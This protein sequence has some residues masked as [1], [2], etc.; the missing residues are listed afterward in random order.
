MICYPG[1]RVLVLSRNFCVQKLNKTHKKREKIMVVQY[2][3][4]Y[5]QVRSTPSY[6]LSFNYFTSSQFL[7]T[8]FF[9]STTAI[10]RRPLVWAG[11]QKCN[12]VFLLTYV[13]TYRT[14]TLLSL[15]SCQLA[16]ARPD[17]H[18][19]LSF[20]S[21]MKTSPPTLTFFC[22]LIPNMMT[23]KCA[24]CNLISPIT[25]LSVHAPSHPS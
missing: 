21:P 20:L 2:F 12:T 16:T 3:C 7:P 15:L 19:L 24:L 9:A 14:A 17:M 11:M 4:T 13:I 18:P 10:L 23:N 6:H 5:Q 1:Y 8:S 22:Q 25:S